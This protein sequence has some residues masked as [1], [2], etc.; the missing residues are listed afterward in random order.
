M[1]KPNN[2]KKKKS[3][4]A[5][6]KIFL[7]LIQEKEIQEISVSNICKLAHINRSTFY[8]NY[9]DIYDLADKIREEMFYNLLE[10]FKEE[11][12]KVITLMII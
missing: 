7:Q 2:Q 1:N 4:E 10:L 5:I 3:Q 12:L 9:L 8:A 6:K 11:A